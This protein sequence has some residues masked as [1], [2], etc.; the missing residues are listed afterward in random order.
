MVTHMATPHK[1]THKTTLHKVTH[2]TTLHKVTHKATLH[3]A[4]HMVTHKATPH[5]ATPHKA[6]PH[7][8]TL[9]KATPHKATPHKATPKVTCRI[10]NRCKL[11]IQLTRSLNILLKYNSM[12]II[13]TCN[14]I[15]MLIIRLTPQQMRGTILTTIRQ[16]G[17]ILME[18]TH[19]R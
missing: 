12:V 13:L 18:P 9:H 4:T 3:R 17:E 10:S 7:K 16:V 19:T 2:K 14:P 15:P 6:T 8:A 1:V 5:K 11:P